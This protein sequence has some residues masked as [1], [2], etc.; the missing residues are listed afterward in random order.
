MY[1]IA[2]TI[3]YFQV[4]RTEICIQEVAWHDQIMNMDVTSQ[5]VDRQHTVYSKGFL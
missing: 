4:N 1:Y 5:A 2:F 3:V